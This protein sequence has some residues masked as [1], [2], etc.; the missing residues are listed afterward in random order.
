MTILNETILE[1]TYSDDNTMEENSSSSNED[2]SDSENENVGKTMFP[3]NTTGENSDKNNSDSEDQNSENSMIVDSVLEEK[4][5][6]NDSEESSSDI[7]SDSENENLGNAGWADAMCKVLN[8]NVPN[9]KNFILSKAK[10]DTD[11]KVKDKTEEIEMVDESGKVT[12]VKKLDPKPLQKTIKQK[13][14]EMLEK[15]KQVLILYFTS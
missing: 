5:K 15:R 4:Q 6:Q 11:I 9:A 10:K 8:T 12:G 1:K 14:K 2:N 7:D 3:H 13:R